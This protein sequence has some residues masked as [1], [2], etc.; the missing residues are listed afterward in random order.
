M[1]NNFT[2]NNEITYVSIKK[3]IKSI[4]FSPYELNDSEVA[5]ESYGDFPIEQLVLPGDKVIKESDPNLDIK[6]VFGDNC[7]LSLF[8]IKSLDLQDYGR[9]EYSYR[10]CHLIGTIDAAKTTKALSIRTLDNFLFTEVGDLDLD[11]LTISVSLPKD[12]KIDKKIK[13]PKVCILGVHCDDYAKFF[14]FSNVQHLKIYGGSVA[15]QINSF[16]LD[17]CKTLTCPPESLLFVDELHP[18][19]EIVILNCIGYDHKTPGI[20]ISPRTQTAKCEQVH[21]LITK[22]RQKFPGIKF[23]VQVSNQRFDLKKLVIIRKGELISQMVHIDPTD[24]EYT[25]GV[26]IRVK[27]GCYFNIDYNYSR[28]KS[29]RQ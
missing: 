28:Q 6:R 7:D 14:D 12:L 25:D 17:N 22:Y 24:Y 29:G 11:E 18:S 1:S 13:V 20:H 16:N 27:P 4:V 21:Q 5:T 2:F 3:N 23:K 26:V 9:V 15:M 19:I 8:S 10:N